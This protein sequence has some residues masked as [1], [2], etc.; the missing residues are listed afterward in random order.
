MPFADISTN[1]WQWVAIIAIAIVLA[2]GYVR[3][4]R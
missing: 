3:P 2:L 4:W 1:D